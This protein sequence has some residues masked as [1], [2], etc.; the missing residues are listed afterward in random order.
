MRLAPDLILN[1]DINMKTRAGH[2][3]SGR[4]QGRKPM[5]PSGPMATFT[6][7]LTQAQKTKLERLGGSRWMRARIDRE[8]PERAPSRGA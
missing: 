5:D 2:G 3:G 4:G 1:Y 8:D 7:R 6:I